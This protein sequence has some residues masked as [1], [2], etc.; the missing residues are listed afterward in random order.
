MAARQHGPLL[1]AS[2]GLGDALRAYLKTTKPTSGYV[3]G[4]LADGVV[5]AVFGQ[6]SH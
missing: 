5:T 4:G 6:P 3:V 1:L 2:G